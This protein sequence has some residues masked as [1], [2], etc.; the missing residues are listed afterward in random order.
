MYKCI[1]CTITASLSPTNICNC[2][3]S[4]TRLLY[5]VVRIKNTDVYNYFKI[6]WAKV[7]LTL[8]A[9]IIKVTLNQ[10]NLCS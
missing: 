6:K 3:T 2:M 1:I 8:S 7:T 9:S 5:I 10:L 4:Y